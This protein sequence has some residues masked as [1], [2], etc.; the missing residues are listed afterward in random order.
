MKVSTAPLLPGSFHPG[1][2]LGYGAASVA[3]QGTNDKAPLPDP[4]SQPAATVLSLG[5][6]EDPFIS[7]K[8]QV[9]RSGEG[10]PTEALN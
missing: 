4:F 8:L 1:K 5:P 10:S 2:R 6:S 7:V 3:H 9:C